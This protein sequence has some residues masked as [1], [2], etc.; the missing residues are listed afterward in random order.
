MN[1]SP[2]S[3]DAARYATW[4][5]WLLVLVVLTAGFSLFEA[6]KNNPNSQV[7]GRIEGGVAEVELV[8]GRG[9]H[10]VANGRINGA[11]A[12]FM[13]DTG[14]TAVAIPAALAS[15]LGLE[16][17]STV[18]VATANGMAEGYLTRLDEVRLGPIVRRD[19]RAIIQPT[20]RGEVLLGMS[21]LRELEL[22]QRDRTLILRQY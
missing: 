14:A 9:G 6:R 2:P 21:F 19:V 8:Q 7:V 22:V 18:T 17:L 1:Q 12:T 11:E 10:Y 4:F 20:L 5:W 16:R 3:T 13:L 15:R